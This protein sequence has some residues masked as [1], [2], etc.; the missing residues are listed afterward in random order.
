MSG[1]VKDAL[2]VYAD[3]QPSL[4]QKVEGNPCGCLIT[5]CSLQDAL[6]TPGAH[7]QDVGHVVVAGS[8]ADIKAVMS[9]VSEFGFSLGL[10]PS[11]SAAALTSCY[12]L[13]G[14]LDSLIDLSLR[15]DP[16]TMDVIRCNGHIM[17]LYAAVGRL[18]LLDARGYKVRLTLALKAAFELVGMRLQAM[19]FKTAGGRTV[20]T[21]ASGCML[22]QRHGQSLASRLIARN[23]SFKAGKISIVVAAPMSVAD[24]VTF[25]AQ[26][27]R[28]RF[29]GTKM[30]STLGYIKSARIELKTESP[31]NV[32]V[33]G[34]NVSKT[35]LVAEVSPGAVRVNIG[36]S[37][38]E[39][40]PAAEALMDRCEVKNLPRGR[41]LS[42]A[43]NRRIPLFSY[44][45]EERFRDLFIALRDDAKTSPTYLVLMVLSTLLATIGLYLNSASVIIGAMLLAPLMAPIV[46]LAMGLVRSDERLSLASVKKTAI[47]IAIALSAA[48]LCSLIIPN[49]MVTPEMQAR[50]NPSLLDLGVAI[51]A[52]IAGAYTKSYKEILQSLAGVAI[53]VALVPPLAVAGIGLGRADFPF[54]LQAFL[55]F[56]TNLVGIILAAALTFRLLGYSPAVRNKRGLAIVAVLL[57][58]ISIPLYLSF[59]KIINTQALEQAWRQERF[60][61]G[62]QYLIVEKAELREQRGRNV[63]YVDLLVRQPLVPGDLAAFKQKLQMHFSQ[64]LII[65]VR[66][67]YI[68]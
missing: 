9:L 24:Y 45:S 50:L 19:T 7:F 21:A 64:D 8:L 65:R 33:D 12:G 62:G 32:M 37:L 31:F 29:K 40:P 36:A 47:G 23:G 28:D 2:F 16:E 57:V 63:L 68:L 54:F 49:M 46:S 15:D 3:D 5:S 53:A 13:P 10:I 25:L 6:S 18:P 44:A 60:L 59:T 30:P 43:R 34:K 11:R 61:V 42:K 39:G 58:L 20:E 56:S 48:G 38:K 41:E 67:T 26:F 14:D 27:L 1:Y 51:L 52:G 17:L 4:I 22:V 55:L 35:P 66:V